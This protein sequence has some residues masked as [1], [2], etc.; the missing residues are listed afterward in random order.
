[1]I[2]LV[3]AALSGGAA[4]V[5]RYGDI[6]HATKLAATVYLPIT[7]NMWLRPL[8]PWMTD[9]HVAALR[10]CIHHAHAVY[11]VG[12]PV[13][14]MRAGPSPWGWGHSYSGDMSL[15][16]AATGDLLA[17]L[18]AGD[19]DRFNAIVDALRKKTYRSRA[20]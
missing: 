15:A 3:A 14:S 2:S 13:A 20:V 16:Y 18:D 11:R 7:G 10:A 12:V 6:V 8:R 9:K 1:M 5:R 17:A 19:T 4:A